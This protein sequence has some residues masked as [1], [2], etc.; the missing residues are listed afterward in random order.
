MTM[1]T[2]IAADGALL[3]RIY[4]DTWPTWS[5]GLSR[6]DYERYNRAQMMTEWG[7]A[8]L[9]R[10]AWVEGAELLAS[11]KRYRLELGFGGSEVPCLGIGAVFTPA[12]ARGRGH[13]A[14]LI[15]AMVEEAVREE[16]RYALLFSEIDPAY[17]VRLGFEPVPIT[18]TY[19]GLK[20]QPRDGAPAVL[21][22]GG[23]ERDLDDIAAMHQARA[24]GYA[25]AQH[26]SPAY[27][28]HAISKRRM[29][30]AFSPPGM[31]QLEFFIAEEGA[32]AVAYVV[33]S[34]GP[35]GQVLEEWGDRDP[36]GAR[37]GAMLQVLAARTPAE[38]VAPLRTWLPDEF[39]PPQ[40]GRLDERQP[41]EVAMLRAI[42]PGGPSVSELA[43]DAFFLKGDAF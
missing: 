8:S 41:H 27:A 14:A 43:R 26:R 40:L 23:D 28:R 5:D 35:E 18:E 16:T 17:Y 9:A 2:L 21:V 3:E 13:A 6:A 15:E 10:V 39:L 11:A 34:R 33:V 1:P 37:L 22:R 29:L 32:S 31:R 36:A 20:P 25:L 7:A 24:A 19:L 4:D 42:A 38:T 30:A 12:H